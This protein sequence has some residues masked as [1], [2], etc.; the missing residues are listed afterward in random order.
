[1]CG[2]R[3]AF[4]SGSD[5]SGGRRLQK[6]RR[7]IFVLRLRERTSMAARVRRACAA[8]AM[9]RKCDGA[10]LAR[11]PAKKDARPRPRRRPLCSSQ[12]PRRHRSKC[13]H[14]VARSFALAASHHPPRTNT[15]PL[16]SW[17]QHPSRMPIKSPRPYSLPPSC[18]PP[19]PHHPCW[20]S[21]LTLQ[22]VSHSH[23]SLSPFSTLW[24]PSP[25]PRHPSPQIALSATSPPVP[26]ASPT[27][28]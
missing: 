22:V 16:L 27:G 9:R 6:W 2:G 4:V 21:Q 12:R 18:P 10:S 7:Q 25:S 5:S 3:L 24:R 14:D 19:P 17:T 26:H 13:A 28:S 1:M 20:R 8:R 11:A 23:L 15:L